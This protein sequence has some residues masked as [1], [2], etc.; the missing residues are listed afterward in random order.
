MGADGVEV[1]A[2]SS[3]TAAGLKPLNVIQ[4][5]KASSQAA[6]GRV[7][8]KEIVDTWAQAPNSVPIDAASSIGAPIRPIVGMI[9]GMS[10]VRY[11]TVPMHR[12]LM[13]GMIPGPNRNVQ[14]CRATSARPVVT[15]DVASA[16]DAPALWRVTR[17]RTLRTP[18]M[19][20]AASMTLDVTKPRDAVWLW[21]LATG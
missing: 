2:G 13:A 11:I 8:K 21:R 7:A 16:P 1:S 9:R 5:P 14:S 12:A 17:D 4:T 19:I 18:T 15:I 6:I 3:A 10:P 20:I